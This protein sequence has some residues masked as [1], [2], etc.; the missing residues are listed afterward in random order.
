MYMDTFEW[1]DNVLFDWIKMYILFL[2]CLP[3]L[4]YLM[5]YE[6]LSLPVANEIVLSSPQFAKIT[7]YTQL[8][9][10]AF[11]LDATLE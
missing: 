4:F 10:I 1:C 3:A 5:Q 2:L 11:F 8:D 7:K 6:P 9:Q